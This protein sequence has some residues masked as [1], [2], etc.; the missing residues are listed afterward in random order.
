MGVEDGRFLAACTSHPSPWIP[1]F[2]GMTV[3]VRRSR[4]A[5]MNDLQFTLTPTLSLRERELAA[6]NL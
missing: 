2:T 4:F 5:G 1:V 6:R 3:V